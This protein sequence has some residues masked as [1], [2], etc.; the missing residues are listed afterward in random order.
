ME[1][2]GGCF[3]ESGWRVR[4]LRHGAKPSAPRMVS[5]AAL[6]LHGRSDQVFAPPPSRRGR[7]R[8]RAALS[9]GVTEGAN[10]ARRLP[11]IPW[12]KSGGHG[13]ICIRRTAGMVRPACLKL[14]ERRQGR[15]RYGDV[16]AVPPPFDQSK[17]A[18]PTHK[19][20]SL[21]RVLARRTVGERRW[22]DPR[23]AAPRPNMPA[24]A[25]GQTVTPA[26]AVRDSERTLGESALGP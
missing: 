8:W 19:A 14:D 10:Q 1:V 25:I 24:S 7:G 13:R 4:P 5:P 20:I 22:R 18:E 11:C 16:S 21:Y 3:G 2:G 12:A 17:L 26:Q 9:C 6:R 15:R 23:A